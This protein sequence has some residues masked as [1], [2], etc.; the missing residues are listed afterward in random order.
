MKTPPTTAIRAE[1]TSPIVKDGFPGKRDVAI[2]VKFIQQISTN[3]VLPG[4]TSK[5]TLIQVGEL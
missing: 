4:R 2:S 5:M 3:G 1:T